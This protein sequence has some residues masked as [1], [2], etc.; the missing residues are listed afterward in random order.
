MRVGS[1]V[2]LQSAAEDSV[3]GGPLPISG[4]RERQVVKGGAL[5]IV[6]LA[7][8][9]APVA[10]CTVMLLHQSLLLADVLRVEEACCLLADDRDVILRAG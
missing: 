9:E 5:G 3:D 7:P 1:S 4:L 2:V 10:V 6:D 8:E